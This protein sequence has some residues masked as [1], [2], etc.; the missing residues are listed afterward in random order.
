MTIPTC[1]PDRKH[2]AK[3]L[4]KS[5]WCNLQYKNNPE[6]REKFKARVKRS[7]DKKK[8]ADPE[9]NAR[10]QRIWRKK[11]PEKF[12]FLMAKAYFKKLS[13]EDKL[14]IFRGEY[15]KEKKQ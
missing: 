9:W 2:Y 14:K 13:Q 11:N 4:C 8:K 6:Y 3:N 15:G 12:N 1:H 10:R 7:Q 5:C